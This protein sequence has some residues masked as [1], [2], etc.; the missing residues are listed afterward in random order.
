M[1]SPHDPLPDHPQSLLGQVGEL[2]SMTNP[3]TFTP[4][5]DA[6]GLARALDSLSFDLHVRHTGKLLAS[7]DRQFSL[8]AAGG[9]GDPLSSGGS[10]V[11]AQRSLPNLTVQQQRSVAMRSQSVRLR[12][13]AAPPRMP[14]DRWNMHRSPRHGTHP[15]LRLCEL[16]GQKAKIDE[17][18][19]SSRRKQLTGAGGADASRSSPSSPASSR[20]IPRA[21]RVK[22]GSDIEAKM[23]DWDTYYPGTVY[24]A[25]ADGTYD[26][27]F[28][29]GDRKRGV[30]K[31]QMRP[32]GSTDDGNAD[33]GRYSTARKK[34]DAG[35][36]GSKDTSRL[37]APATAGSRAVPKRQGR[38]LRLSQRDRVARRNESVLRAFVSMLQASRSIYGKRPESLRG[39]FQAVDTDANGTIDKTEL[40][41]ALQRLGLGLDPKA[42]EELCA[43]IDENG[44][45]VIAYHELVA[46][47]VQITKAAG[48]RKRHL[49]A[50]TKH[51]TTGSRSVAKRKRDGP[52][53]VARRRSAASRD[54]EQDGGLLTRFVTLVLEWA[55]EGH[56]SLT[57]KVLEKLRRAF[58]NHERR[59]DGLRHPSH[60]NEPTEGEERGTTDQKEEGDDANTGHTTSHHNHNAADTR[61]AKK[62]HHHHHHH[63]HHQVVRGLVSGKVFVK[64]VCETGIGM[65]G[66]ETEVAQIALGLLRLHSTSSRHHRR[67]HH[68]H[69]T[70]PNAV[71]RELHDKYHEGRIPYHTFL[72]SAAKRL[73]KHFANAQ[74][75]KRDGATTRAI[76][77]RRQLM[78]RLGESE[79]AFAVFKAASARI[80]EEVAFARRAVRKHPRTHLYEKASTWSDEDKTLEVADF[81]DPTVLNTSLST[82]AFFS[83]VRDLGITLSGEELPALWAGL[84]LDERDA[85]RAAGHSNLLDHRAEDARVARLHA[86]NEAKVIAK[87][88]VLHRRHVKQEYAVR[89]DKLKARRVDAFRLRAFDRTLAKLEDGGAVEERF[90]AALN[91]IRSSLRLLDIASG[92]ILQIFAL[93]DDDGDGNISRAEFQIACE[94]I[95]CDLT[96]SEVGACFDMLDPNG[97]D[98]IDLDEF[99][100]AWFNKGS[101]L[102]TIDTGESTTSVRCQRELRDK[103]LQEMERINRMY[104]ERSDL[105]RSVAEAAVHGW[106]HH[107]ATSEEED[108]DA[109]AEKE[110]EARDVLNDS[111]S[112]SSSYSDSVE[113]G[114]YSGD[115]FEAESPSRGPGAEEDAGYDGEGE[116]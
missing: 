106:D 76:E 101:I 95:G 30:H 43:A 96:E 104:G 67:H 60:H 98:G 116:A 70:Q 50:S 44:D 57:S 108:D 31:Y 80:L 1:A 26:V 7:G 65:G 114:E 115:E 46:S 51:H 6:A 93:F 62:G 68:H 16:T 18:T 89:M 41:Q 58:M 94:R 113:S 11:Y 5:Q 28:N 27:R 69:K 23:E 3:D 90:A 87:F 52:E 73:R 77:T 34:N 54:D 22:V 17:W 66:Q 71:E 97:D 45:G 53:R 14:M 32:V 92:D 83:L 107:A 48:K 112:S 84:R 20:I 74:R 25:N 59:R 10:S 88:K 64:V 24:R 75:A 15:Y 100:Y 86:V 35:E 109:D 37:F 111:S 9:P 38:T 49:Q 61:D 13:T 33:T 56:H 55:S 29:D 99:R 39:V 12:P 102:R 85:L 36:A 2:L 42:V 21:F 4:A 78:A 47:I 8:P 79:H 40:Q 81:L 63:H 105:V 82:D 91:K 103:E 19:H 110:E 72:D